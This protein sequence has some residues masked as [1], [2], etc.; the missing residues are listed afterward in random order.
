ME[1]FA[2][3]YLPFEAFFFLFSTF[4]FHRH[5]TVDERLERMQREENEKEV[6]Q[7][8]INLNSTFLSEENVF[9]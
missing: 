3:F 1:G 5:E 2:I 7:F 4:P 9:V 8:K 6:Q